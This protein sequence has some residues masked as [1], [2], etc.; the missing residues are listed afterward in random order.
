VINLSRASES[1][2]EPYPAEYARSIDLVDKL[3]LQVV[4][5]EALK[6]K[7]FEISY[8][9]GKVSFQRE[10]LPQ[11]V[12]SGGKLGDSKIFLKP[13]SRT[14]TIY[15]WGSAELKNSCIKPQHELLDD[16]TSVL[17]LEKPEAALSISIKSR[18]LLHKLSDLPKELQNSDLFKWIRYAIP[19]SHIGR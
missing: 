7:D 8:I 11:E 14:E 6:A 4:L 1:R 9:V 3:G 15:K 12:R 17:G 13:I 18:L 19:L 5:M 16:I 2:P 10:K